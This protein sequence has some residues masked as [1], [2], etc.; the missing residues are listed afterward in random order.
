MTKLVMTLIAV[1]IATGALFAAIAAGASPSTGG[2]THPLAHHP[3]GHP[4]A[5]AAG[6]KLGIGSG[7][8]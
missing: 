1:T 7:S 2:R 5:K 4:L 3:H 6:S 8:Y